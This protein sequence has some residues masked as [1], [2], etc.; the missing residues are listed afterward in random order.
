M[1]LIVGASLVTERTTGVY[2]CNH[3]NFTF[4]IAEPVEEYEQFGDLNAYGVCDSP[5]QLLAA[6]D[7]E[8]DPRAICISVVEL[9]R[10]DQPDNGGWR[11]HK[12]GPYI[13]TQ[14]PQ[15]EYL[16]DEPEIKTV[17]CYHAYVL[18][19]RNANAQ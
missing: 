2:E 4:E 18:T 5:E 1:E 11:W 8:S 19:D 17:W 6:Y 12:W 13:G 3:F 9:H 10:E 7:F 15:C 16:H 14:N